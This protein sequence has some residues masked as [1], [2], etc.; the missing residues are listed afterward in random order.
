MALDRIRKLHSTTTCSGG[1]ISILH[2]PSGSRAGER[3]R[4]WRVAAK[5]ERGGTP[6]GG[7][8]FQGSDT[9]PT[10]L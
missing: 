8:S 4:W 1:V 5:V 6:G 9:S 10:Y 7:E 3:E 2:S